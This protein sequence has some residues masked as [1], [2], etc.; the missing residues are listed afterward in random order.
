MLNIYSNLFTVALYEI[1]TGKKKNLKSMEMLGVGL[2]YQ[3][4]WNLSC[5][6]KICD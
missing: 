4:V 5:N 1:S 6:L 3:I 2:P